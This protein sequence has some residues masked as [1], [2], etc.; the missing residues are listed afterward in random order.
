MEAVNVVVVEV[1]VSVVLVVMVVVNNS[2][3]CLLCGGRGSC[4][5]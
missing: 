2:V 3:G 4:G 5:C 1:V